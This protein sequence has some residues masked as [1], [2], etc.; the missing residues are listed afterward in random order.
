MIAFGA[1]A[2]VRRAVRHAAGLAN[3]RV[4]LADGLLVHATLRDAV[5]RTE[6]LGAHGAAG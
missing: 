1:D 5:I 6:V 4:L 3:A 2:F